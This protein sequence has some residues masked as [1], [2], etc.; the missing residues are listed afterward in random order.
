MQN[1]QD[2]WKLKNSVRTNSPVRANS[3][4]V[5]QK[6]ESGVGWEERVV[7]LEENRATSLRRVRKVWRS[8]AESKDS[9]IFAEIE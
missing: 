5:G 7:M 2:V 9:A 8:A 1:L 3:P 6:K 4:D